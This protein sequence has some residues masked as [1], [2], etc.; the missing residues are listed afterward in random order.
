[1]PPPPSSPHPPPPPPP[2]RSWTSCLPCRSCSA[3]PS[4]SALS[5]PSHPSCGHS[6]PLHCPPPRRTAPSD[7]RW[8]GI[9]GRGGATWSNITARRR[10]ASTATATPLA[11]RCTPPR[12]RPP[13]RRGRRQQVAKGSKKRRMGGR[14][15]WRRTPRFYDLRL[16]WRASNGRNL[17]C[18]LCPSA[19]SRWRRFLLGTA[20]I[21]GRSPVATG[22]Q[23]ASSLPSP[24]PRPSTPPCSS[25][26]ATFGR[27][28]ASCLRC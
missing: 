16:R 20:D 10:D 22:H 15:W 28:P 14:V 5:A 26:T 4:L 11:P 24:L 12:K 8:S 17:L 1:M 21:S 3:S 18:C 9:R 7:W 23:E 13:V 19:S 25:L 2:S 27:S 6:P